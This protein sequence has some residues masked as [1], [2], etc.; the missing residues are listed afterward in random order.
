MLDQQNADRNHKMGCVEM[1][2]AHGSHER[3]EKCIQYFGWEI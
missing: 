2:G 1:V 3:E